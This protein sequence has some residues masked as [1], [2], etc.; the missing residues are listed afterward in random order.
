MAFKIVG[1]PLGFRRD[2]LEAERRRAA[3]ARLP[4]TADE[5][6]ARSKAR[7]AAA[8]ARL[9]KLRNLQPLTDEDYQA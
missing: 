5:R 4:A 7:L 3:A 9:E 2:L 8:L 6:A 1:R